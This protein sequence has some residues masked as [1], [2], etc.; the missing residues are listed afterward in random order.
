[1]DAK[2]KKII[3]KWEL[4]HSLAHGSGDPLAKFT[5]EMAWAH[6]HAVETAIRACI[7][8]VI[9]VDQF[10]AGMIRTVIVDRAAFHQDTPSDGY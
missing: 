1:M 8:P 5:K 9:I 7:D 2:W 3:A 4:A 6:A 10:N